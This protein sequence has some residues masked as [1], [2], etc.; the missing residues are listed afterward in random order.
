MKF[1]TADIIITDDEGYLILKGMLPEDAIVWTR[2]VGKKVAVKLKDDIDLDYL[3]KNL[4][5]LT[6]TLT[7]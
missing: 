3:V 7:L 2:S 4:N 6:R 5:S 1:R